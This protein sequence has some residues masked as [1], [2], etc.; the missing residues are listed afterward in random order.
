MKVIA[1]ARGY[2]DSRV[3]EPGQTFDVEEGESASWF[4]PLEK[5]PPPAPAVAPLPEPVTLSELHQIAHPDGREQK[6]PRK[7]K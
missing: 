6:T 1:T 7:K 4:V 5:A 2:R 3:W